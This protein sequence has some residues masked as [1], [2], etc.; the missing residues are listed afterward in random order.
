MNEGDRVHLDNGKCI[1]CG[2]CVQIAEDAGEEIGLAY[3]GRGFN[4]KI[5]APFGKSLVRG[6]GKIRCRLCPGLSNRCA[7]IRGE[8][9]PT[10]PFSRDSITTCPWLPS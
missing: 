3:E 6:L 5:V 7:Q 10:N 9:K 4:T 1:Q 2:L 8:L